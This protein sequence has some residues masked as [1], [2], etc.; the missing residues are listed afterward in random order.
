MKER[1]T[2]FKKKSFFQGVSNHTTGVCNLAIW[3]Q[4]RQVEKNKD[5]N[6]C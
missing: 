5:A 3:T 2:K 4:L 6:C 1:K